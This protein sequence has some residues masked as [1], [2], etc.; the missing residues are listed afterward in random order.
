[1]LI[2]KIFSKVDIKKVKITI[3]SRV[4][5]GN[6]D[7]IRSQFCYERTVREFSSVSVFLF[8]STQYDYHHHWLYWNQHFVMRRLIISRTRF[9]HAFIINDVANDFLL[10]IY[11]CSWF[12][13]EMPVNLIQL[14]AFDVDL[15]VLQINWWEIN[16]EATICRAID[17]LLSASLSCSLPPSLQ[18]DKLSMSSKKLK[19]SWEAHNYGHYDHAM[20]SKSFSQIQHWNVTNSNARKHCQ[21]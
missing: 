11:R 21:K 4:R 17:F 19:V 13:S 7:I 8:C 6:V 5:R 3:G 20:K 10:S 15:L 18:L 1:M 2:E 14:V 12:C 16:F 9:I